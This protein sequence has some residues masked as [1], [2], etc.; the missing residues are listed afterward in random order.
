MDSFMQPPRTNEI[1]IVFLNHGVRYLYPTEICSGYQV[2]SNYPWNESSNLITLIRHNFRVNNF[3][4]FPPVQREDNFWSKL[5]SCIYCITHELSCH[6]HASEITRTPNGEV[7]N[8]PMLYWQWI[9]HGW[10]HNLGSKDNCSVNWQYSKETC[11]LQ[12]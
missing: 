2:L 4:L 10:W 5:R 7:S 6:A 1:G 12:L 9:S 11:E 8:K 3:K